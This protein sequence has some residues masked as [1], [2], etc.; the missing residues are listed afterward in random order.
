MWAPVFAGAAGTG[1]PWY[2]NKLPIS[3]FLSEMG[4]IRKFWS[5]LESLVD[6]LGCSM[7][8][9]SWQ[10]LLPSNLTT[11]VEAVGMDAECRLKAGSKSAAIVWLHQKSDTC[12]TEPNATIPTF[13]LEIPLRQTR[14]ARWSYPRP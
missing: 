1:L 2:W 9:M 12:L 11:N 13:Q 8:H 10:P 3:W 5:L 14:G 6:G 4:G 7:A